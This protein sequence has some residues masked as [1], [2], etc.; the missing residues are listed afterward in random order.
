M[1]RLG[2]A[3][4]LSRA[5]FVLARRD[6]LL[7][8]EYHQRLPLFARLFSKF[9]RLFAKPERADNPGERF[10]Q[11]LEALGPSYVKLGQFLSTRADILDPRFARGLA[12]LKD[13]VPP[14]PHAKA[15]ESIEAEFGAPLESLFAELG[16]SVAAA[17]VAQVHPAVTTEGESVAVK[18]LRP[19]IEQR[20]VRDIEAMKLAAR[21]THRFLPDT[22]RFRP[23]DLV[24]TLARSL[25]LE[26]DLRLE[27]AA[28]S[29][30]ADLAPGLD[31]F[32]VPSP[33][34][35]R[36]G[37]RVLTTNW[38]DGIKLSDMA[39]IEASGI[40]QR[41]LAETV[42]QTFLGS[43]LEF[44]VFHADMHEG[45]LFADHDGRLIAVD[46]GIM[47]RL[48]R[49]ERRYLAE[50]IYGFLERDYD[51]AARAHFDAGYVED[52]YDHA[53]FAAALR[54]VGEPIYG[55]KAEEVSMSR[56]LLQLLEITDLFNMRLRPELVLLQKTMVQAEGVARRLDPSLDM[57]AASRPIVE[58]FLRAELGP[59]GVALD[60]LDD[61]RRLRSAMRRMPQAI[62]D[63][64][65]AA[66]HWKDGGVALDGPTVHELSREIGQARS[67]ATLAIWL[68]AAAS[69][70]GA[71][72][73]WLA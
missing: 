29:N 12:R 20:V 65:D 3:W 60:A 28:A 55:R 57:W 67:T 24:D 14:F 49:A 59:E 71:L 31:N 23:L 43:A 41:A 22:R 30:L 56:V 4:R 32:G 53:D 73:L 7:P 72:A 38:V 45:N 15:V 1:S 61:L 13:S 8:R 5:V 46:F 26:M 27:A 54:A 9:T 44:G 6:A 10:A 70:A 37:K 18:V 34:W 39:A 16:Q 52:D 47:G 62:E 51:R 58:R 25:Q 36:C 69:I 21:L 68:I 50:I 19:G 66:A 42:I 40:D 11:A 48:G 64:A 2:S 63:L 33:D 35:R 17:S